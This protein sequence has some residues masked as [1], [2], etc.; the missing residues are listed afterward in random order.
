M[1]RGLKIIIIVFASIISLMVLISLFIF[2]G[3]PI[4]DKIM[5]NKALNTGDVS[6]CH[7]IKSYFFTPGSEGTCISLVAQKNNDVSICETGNELQ[8]DDCYAV[9]AYYKN[10]EALCVEPQCSKTL[11]NYC[12]TNGCDTIDDYK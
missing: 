3:S 9:Y 1:K 10:D 8:K 5:F 12:K 7:K 11:F 4:Y 6:Y 2:V